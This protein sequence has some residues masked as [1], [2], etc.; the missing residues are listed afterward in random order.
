M[1]MDR[2][3]IEI[4]GLSE[5]RWNTSG[6]TILSSGHTIVYSGN[7]SKDDIHNTGAGCMLTK[8]AARVLLE[9]NQVSPGIISERFE[10]KFQKSTII[11]EYALINNAD[12]DE[13]EY[14]H[15]F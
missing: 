1:N 9:Y 10:P 8:Q 6:M 7:P 12:E 15:L 11:R 3:N 4:L 13:R 14:F 2:Y 5:V